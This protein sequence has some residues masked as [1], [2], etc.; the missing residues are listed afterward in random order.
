MSQQALPKDWD[1]VEP[2]LASG[3]RV[4][5]ATILQL[6]SLELFPS[7]DIHRRTVLQRRA[8]QY[9]LPLEFVR[10]VFY[11]PAGLLPRL[12]RQS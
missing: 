9:H 8:D 7:S 6:R 1:T 2:I 5:V 3:I 10:R 4:S 11:L 12:L